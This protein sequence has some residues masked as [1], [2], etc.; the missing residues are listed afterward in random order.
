MR[1][2]SELIEVITVEDKI[3]KIRDKYE[4]E[5]MKING[6]VGVGVGKKVV[7][8]KESGQ[9]AIIVFVAKKLPRSQLEKTSIIPESLEGIPVDVQEVGVVK[10]LKIKKGSEPCH[11]MKS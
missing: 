2:S 5:L 8:G 1:T 3:R 6:V 4:Q 10:A 11:I 7:A 9:L